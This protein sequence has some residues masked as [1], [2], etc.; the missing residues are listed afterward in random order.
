MKKIPNYVEN[1]II[2]LFYVLVI[3]NVTFEPKNET[4]STLFLLIFSVL[5]W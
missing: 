4:K 1:F 3:H 5:L 2:A